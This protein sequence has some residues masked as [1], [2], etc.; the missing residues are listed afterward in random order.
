MSF[1][2]IRP[3]PHCPF[4]ND[5]EGYLRPER[6]SEIVQSLLVGDMTFPCHE[7]VDRD[8]EGE[9]ITDFE[10]EHCAGAMIFMEKLGQP[11][12]L[13][14][15]GERVG[16]YGRGKLDMDAPVVSTPE[17]FIALHGGDLEEEGEPCEIC[18]PDCEAPAGYM[19]AG[20]PVTNYVPPGLTSSCPNCGT[21]IC[22]TCTCYCEQE[23]E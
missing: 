1:A 20:G 5:N 10:T 14:R 17:E 3:C 18:D 8:D 16:F 12:Q 22:G 11:N 13:M 15:V 6:A 23:D 9:P 4:R 7:T 21:I 2:L 19:G